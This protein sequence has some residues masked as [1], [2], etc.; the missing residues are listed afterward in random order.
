MFMTENV[1]AA[2]LSLPMELERLG[3]KLATGLS[4]SHNGQRVTAARPLHIRASPKLWNGS[5]RLVGWSIF[6]HGA[7]QVVIRDGRDADA[8]P[9]AVAKLAA[10]QSETIWLGP[11]GISMGEGVYL[12]V[13]PGVES[14]EGAVWL[15]VVD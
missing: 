3:A 4:E 15:G 1:Q 13:A 5:G 8:D 11:G 14:I 2:L 12:D 7:V 10:G 9:V 6:A